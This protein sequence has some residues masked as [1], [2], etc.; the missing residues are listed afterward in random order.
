MTKEQTT[1]LFVLYREFGDMAARDELVLHNI[2]FAIKCATAYQNR[3]KHV[4]IEDMTSY[5][6]IGMMKAI[7]KFDYKGK[8]KFITYCVYWIMDSMRDYVYKYESLIRYPQA[9]HR[10]IIKKYKENEFGEEEEAILSN[11]I[12]SCSGDSQSE[13]GA[14]VLDTIDDGSFDEFE[15]ALRQQNI[16]TKIRG[17]LSKLSKVES[18]ILVLMYGIN[19]G[20]TRSSREIMAKMKLSRKEFTKNRDS[21]MVKIKEFLEAA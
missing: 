10:D 11:I 14:D 17:A 6:I 5:A 15:E 12:G 3:F 7:D 18:D 13:E 16:S 1:K 8:N 4:D 2:P 21:A 20:V 19:D 9:V